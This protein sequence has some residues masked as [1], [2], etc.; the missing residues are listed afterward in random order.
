MAGSKRQFR[1]VCDD[2]ATT[3]NIVADEDQTEFVNGVLLSTE[4]AP[5]PGV[6]VLPVATKCRYA[7]YK[8]ADGLYTRKV[9]V[10]RPSVVAS[11]PPS[12]QTRVSGGDPAQAAVLVT[13]NLVKSNAEKFPRGNPADTGLN[14]GDNPG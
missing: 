10:L 6:V 8:S 5:L 2:G 9:I 12:F 11:L 4:T 1:Y 7:R 14:D 13:L 3:F